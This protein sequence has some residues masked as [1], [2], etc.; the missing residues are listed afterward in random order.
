LVSPPRLRLTRRSWYLLAVSSRHSIEK[1]VFGQHGFNAS[2]YLV[3]PNIGD[4]T[5][6]LETGRAELY[7]LSTENGEGDV[8]HRT[9][10]GDVGWLSQSLSFSVK[11]GVRYWCGQSLVSAWSQRV[12]SIGCSIL[13]VCRIF[14][15]SIPF[16]IVKLR[17]WDDLVSIGRQSAGIFGFL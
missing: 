8:G 11:L 15:V 13:A 6:I 7:S 1:R 9:W 12:V 14:V 2:V 4:P 16:Q 17:S 3:A 5:Q 10:V